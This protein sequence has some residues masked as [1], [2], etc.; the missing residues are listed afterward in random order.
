LILGV[1][2]AAELEDELSRA[3]IFHRPPS[4]L[5][6]PILALSAA[7]VLGVLGL[8]AVVRSIRSRSAPLSSPVA[9][10]E[11]GW[12]KWREQRGLPPAVRGEQNPS[13]KTSNVPGEA[14]WYPDPQRADTLRY[15]NGD[16]W[17][18]HFAPSATASS[19]Q[20]S[21]TPSQMAAAAIGA[22]SVIGLILSLQSASLITGTG[23]LW[24]GVALSIG[25]AIAAGILR[26][27]VP[28]AVVVATVLIAIIALSNAS[29]VEEELQ[30]RQI[31]IQSDLG[32]LGIP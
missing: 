11:K 25:A 29:S 28:T 9:S 5:L 32:D 1:G 6:E 3:R 21:E 2:G 31:Q 30:D 16:D 22:C 23:K 26:K 24:T 4:D 14:G 27:T 19:S 17:E 10:M 15:W 8:W 18:D 13:T 7:A 12:D 20:P